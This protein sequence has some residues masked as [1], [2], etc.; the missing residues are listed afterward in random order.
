MTMLQDQA[1]AQFLRQAIRLATD[2]VEQG[3]APFGALVVLDGQ[4]VGTGV[5]TAAQDQDPTAHAEV[6]AIRDACRRLGTLDLT[7]AVMVS[8]CEPCALCHVACMLAQ[9]GEIIYAAPRESVPGNGKARPDLVR[10]QDTLRSMAG[11]SIQYVPTEGA[12][13]PFERYVEKGRPS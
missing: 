1:R 5:N 9:V 8:S 10:M 2:N 13:E 6:A 3:R 12:D 4:V 11:D 7:G